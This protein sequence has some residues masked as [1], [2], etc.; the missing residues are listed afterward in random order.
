MYTKKVDIP[1]LNT[2]NLKILSQEET[3]NL[4][5]EY[6]QG[7]KEANEKAFTESNKVIM[8]KL[9]EWH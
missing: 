3:N 1:R 8:D 6:Q 7:N 5:K 9:S 4:F 2:T